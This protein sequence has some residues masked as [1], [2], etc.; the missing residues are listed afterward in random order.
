MRYFYISYQAQVLTS[1]VTA[2]FYRRNAKYPSLTELEETIVDLKPHLKGANIVVLSIS[3]MREE[4]MK[5]FNPIAYEQ[6][7][8]NDSAP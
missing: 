8:R 7:T 6:L 3:E 1:E 2:S 4:D 5:V